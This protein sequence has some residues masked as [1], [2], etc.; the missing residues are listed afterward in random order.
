MTDFPEVMPFP[1]ARM[2]PQSR[3]TPFGY[4]DHP[5]S[6]RRVLDPF[7]APETLLESQDHEPVFNTGPGPI[8]ARPLPAPAPSL[9]AALAQDR[10]SGP[11]APGLTLEAWLHPDLALPC[12][13]GRPLFAFRLD[14]KSGV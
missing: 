4:D 2:A 7:T 10:A 11:A 12:P 1:G 14:R 13:A 6:L 3:C 8:E 5:S 9:L